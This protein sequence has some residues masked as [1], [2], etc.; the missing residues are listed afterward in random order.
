MVVI[1][2]DGV[3]NYMS[4]FLSD[5]WMISHDLMQ[6]EES[7]EDNSSWWS[8]KQIRLL[9]LATPCTISPGFFF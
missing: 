6:E 4:K 7:C 3:R 5:E 2:P 1:M 8:K 9:E